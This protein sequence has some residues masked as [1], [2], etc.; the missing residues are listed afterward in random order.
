MTS[1]VNSKINERTGK[2]G[3]R[4]SAQ[5]DALADAEDAE[6]LKNATSKIGSM[7]GADGKTPL[8]TAQLIQMA[9]GQDVT[10]DG[11]ATG[12]VIHPSR[13]F[14]QHA[15]RAATQKAAAVANVSEA[16]Q[17]LNASKGMETALERK[18]LAAALRTSSVTAK[19]PWLTGK[20]LGAIEQGGITSAEAAIMAI[21]DG[22]VTAEALAS[23]DVT[24]VKHLV[25]TVTAMPAGPDRVNAIAA[26]K[27]AEL[28]YQANPLLHDKVV[29]GQ[30]HDT[31]ISSITSI[32]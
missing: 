21:N 25:D 24:S 19:A 22:K 13:T 16:H 32:V 2:F 11:T 29:K 5:G 4:A 7:T 28:G 8:S 14:D 31:A 30:G 6:L 10:H 20:T 3:S 12:T 15:R 23:G 1:A 17:L 26:L 18:T 9:S 27:Q